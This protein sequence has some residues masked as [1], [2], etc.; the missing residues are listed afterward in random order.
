MN[1]KLKRIIKRFW[2]P[3]GQCI[4]AIMVIAVT[5]YY[6]NCYISEGKSLNFT[7]ED[8]SILLLFGVSAI[9]TSI[10]LIRLT[11]KIARLESALLEVS[12]EITEIEDNNVHLSR[13][14]HELILELSRKFGV[15]SIEKK[16]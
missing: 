3:V 4:L 8:M 12:R 10:I 5:I 15:G 1:G 11:V 14:T 13:V 16:S 7:P 9:C 2:K 6:G